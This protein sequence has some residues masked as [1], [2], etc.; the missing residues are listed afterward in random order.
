MT[1]RD[2]ARRAHHV[3]RRAGRGLLVVFVS[4]IAGFAATDARA[5]ILGDPVDVSADFYKM[6]PVYFIGNRV[7]S[8]DPATGSG[9]LEW[10]RYLRST[11]L[12]FNKVDVTLAKGRATEFPGTEYDE[13]PQ[14][15]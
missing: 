15:P 10:A 5:Q 1:K 4:M 8:F 6:E 14:L 7:V 12:S 3:L 13:N 11:T 2:G 9:S